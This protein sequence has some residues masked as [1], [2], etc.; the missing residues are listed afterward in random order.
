MPF[1]DVLWNASLEFPPSLFAKL[2]AI[3][4]QTLHANAEK[5]ITF[6]TKHYYYFG[7]MNTF[8]Y[9]CC[10]LYDSMMSYPEMKSYNEQTIKYKKENHKIV[11]QNLV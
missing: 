3:E 9:N 7:E 1:V 2:L 4:D 6:L 11:S 8:K 10:Q 5:E